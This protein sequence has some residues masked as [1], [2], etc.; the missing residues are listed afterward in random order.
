MEKSSSRRSVAPACWKIS[1]EEGRGEDRRKIPIAGGKVARERRTEREILFLVVADGVQSIRF[2]L[3]EAIH[4]AAIDLGATTCVAVV[5]IGIGASGKIGRQFVGRLEH[6]I[7]VRELQA[8]LRA[9][10]V[11]KPS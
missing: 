9:V 4:L 8:R 5:G 7:L 6:A 3:E 10:G 11:R 1:I 2:R